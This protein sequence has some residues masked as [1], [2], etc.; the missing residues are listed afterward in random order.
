MHHRHPFFRTDRAELLGAGGADF[1]PSFCMVT[2]CKMYILR[3]RSLLRKVN[4]A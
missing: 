2:M 3:G 1:S 4:K